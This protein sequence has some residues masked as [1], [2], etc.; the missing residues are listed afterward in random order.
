MTS[1]RTISDNYGLGNKPKAL[2]GDYSPATAYMGVEV[3]V[4]NVPYLLSTARIRGANDDATG[5]KEPFIIKTDGSLRDN[6]AEVVTNITPSTKVARVFYDIL[7]LLNEKDKP[8]FSSR[9]S[10]HVHLNVLDLTSAQLKVLIYSYLVLEPLIFKF[11]AEPRR[12]NIY[13]NRLS[14]TYHI[15]PKQND[16]AKYTGLNLRTV[17]T[18]GTVEFRHL[19]GTEDVNKFR[20]WVNVIAD[21]YSFA[22][23]HKERAF[24]RFFNRIAQLNTDSVYLEFLSEL[25]PTSHR[26][27][28]GSIEEYDLHKDLYN[29][30]CYVKQ[31]RQGSFV[32]Y[33]KPLLV[34]SIDPTQTETAMQKIVREHREAQANVN[35]FAAVNPFLNEAQAVARNPAADVFAP[36]PPPQPTR[37]RAGRLINPRIVPREAPPV[38]QQQ[39]DALDWGQVGGFFIADNN[40]Q[41]EF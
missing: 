8:K 38:V 41:G 30:V 12:N 23:N 21:L 24:T 17:S 35:L 1:Q 22:Y 34:R 20:I 31:Q 29:A 2:I 33:I 9:T 4:E 19:E 6:G 37:N 5:Y 25:L 28:L 27:F 15:L 18:L 16:W 10:I 13:C 32:E 3:E 14:E 39:G 11:I 40:E 26:E 36:P 7:Q